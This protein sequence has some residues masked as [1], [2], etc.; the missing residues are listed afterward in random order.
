MAIAAGAKVAMLDVSD[1]KVGPPAQ[2]IGAI[3]I[4]ADLSDPSQPGPAVERAANAMGKLDGVVNCAGLSSPFAL[5]ELTPDI[6]N[7][8]LAVNLTAPYLI[9]RTALPWLKQAPNASVVN[10]ASGAGI[11]PTS[12]GKG[13]SAYASSK[14]G[15]MGL[16]RSL[17]AEFAPAIRVNA[18]MPGL[19]DTP[20]VRNRL[21][22]PPP[23]SNY[24]MN[25]AA[26]PSEI[27]AAVIFLLSDSASFVT[28]STLAVDGGR[29]FH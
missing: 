16:T 29:T 15:L 28:G 22:G 8:I 23:A 14:A 19:T 5:P 10:V 11:L 18:I 27:A 9:L 13:G 12:I 26:D 6:W 25:R 2:E 3:P 21:G 7:R 17:A 1:D 24:A 4:A 20:M